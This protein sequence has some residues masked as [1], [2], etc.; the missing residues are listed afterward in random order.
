M[1]VSKPG[2]LAALV[3]AALALAALSLTACTRMPATTSVPATTATSTAPATLPPASS[4][5]TGSAALTPEPTLEPP[6]VA[7]L[8]SGVAERE[9][10]PGGWVW[11]GGSNSA[12]WL[13]ASALDPV[14]I[15]AGTMRV[16]LAGDVDVDRWTARA[17]T[18]EDTAGASL[19]PL[20]EGV[21]A[22]SFETP[23]PGSWVVAVEVLFA[24]GLGSASYFW[25]VVVT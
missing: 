24:D 2:R 22:P 16:E 6:P 12:P 7:T 10:E 14:E 11:A 20:G 1:P 23:E 5:G 19:S 15:E 18:A 25:N 4:A 21:G 8:V 3:L 17:A 9:G 13:P